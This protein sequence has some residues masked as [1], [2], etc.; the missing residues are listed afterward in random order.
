MI[1]IITTLGRRSVLTT[2]LL[3]GAS[4]GLGAGQ[5]FQGV[6]LSVSKETAPPGGMAQ[7]KVFITEPMPITTGAGQF[8]F[9]A[10]G[11]I[12]GIALMNAAEDV[13]GL[14]I[15]RG[16]DMSFAFVSP[17]GTYGLQ[18]DYPMLTVAGRIPADAPLG[19]KYPFTIN[20]S[21]LVLYSPAGAQY[22]V[23]A[24]PGHL[25]M[26]PGV[27]IHD[28]NP[29]SATVPA[30]T[31]VT[32][33]GSSFTPN[34]K[35]RFSEGKLSQVR[36][37]SPSRIDV[38]VA[39]RTEMHGMMIRAENPDGTRSTYFSYQRTRRDGT[40]ADPLLRD[41][42]PL[43]PP[44]A[45]ISATLAFP[46]AAPDTTY[47]V[48]IQNVETA[49]AFVSLE[50]VDANGIVTAGPTLTIPS[51]RYIVRELSELFGVAP[52]SASAVRV[53]STGPVQVL[54]AAA[55]HVTGGATPILPN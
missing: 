34:T 48:A 16:G 6:S 9:S 15:V 51:N 19:T 1:P 20:A 43:V 23:E 44:H 5:T 37:I 52:A 33:V 29:G 26:A 35:I 47:G 46:P 30:G 7:M 14:A 39:Q 42:V 21:N 17:S 22:A 18:S 40:S 53:T 54:G 24:K 49:D 27:S 11:S 3:A 2:V 55:D 10:Y 41:A 31:I 25:I 38:I 50:I 32:I 13:A 8:A 36:Y 4:Q 28:V 12:E 45:T